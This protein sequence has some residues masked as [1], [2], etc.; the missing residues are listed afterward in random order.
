MFEVPA[1]FRPAPG[2]A[3]DED[4]DAL[5]DVEFVQRAGGVVEAAFDARAGVRAEVDVDVFD[6]EFVRGVHFG[7]HAGDGFRPEVVLRGAEVDEVRGVDDPRAVEFLLGFVHEEGGL[8]VAEVRVLPHLRRG[9]ENL[10]TVAAERDLPTDRVRDVAVWWFRFV[11]RDLRTGDGNVCADSHIHSLRFGGE[12]YFEAS[13][14]RP[15]GFA[16]SST[17]IVKS[18]A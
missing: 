1:E 13:A 10:P 3:L 8:L 17:R 18:V 6:A 2:V 12:M 5:G 4:G 15:A 11:A 16:T 9:G 7:L 14:T